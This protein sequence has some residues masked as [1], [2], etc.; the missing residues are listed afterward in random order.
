MALVRIHKS[1]GKARLADDQGTERPLQ[2]LS[3]RLLILYREFL[4]LGVTDIYDLPCEVVNEVEFSRPVFDSR[5]VRPVVPPC[6]W[7]RII[8]VIGP[9]GYPAVIFLVVVMARA[10]SMV[11]VFPKRRCQYIRRFGAQLKVPIVKGAILFNVSSDQL[12]VLATFGTTRERILECSVDVE[13]EANRL[14]AADSPPIP[15]VYKGNRESVDTTF[16][17]SERIGDFQGIAPYVLIQIHPVHILHRIA[18]QE[19][20]FRRI[21]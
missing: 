8:E 19:P 11:A 20:P 6:R 10:N 2:F 3:H 7:V 21:V 16:F 1:N 18:L 5:S 15:A 13:T 17:E 12:S 4:V 9:D 14:A